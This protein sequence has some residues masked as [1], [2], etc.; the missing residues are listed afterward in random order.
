MFADLERIHAR[1]RPFEFYTASELWTDE[2]TSAQMLA[3]H[4]DENVDLSSRK[5]AFIDRSAD[6]LIGHLGITSGV[7]VVDF[8]CGPGLYT[9]RLAKT[10]A[11]VTGID[12]SARSIAYARDQARTMGLEIN[13]VNQDYLD[14]V[15]QDRFDVVLMIFCDL[16]A[17]SP[18]QRAIML[19]KSPSR[20]ASWGTLHPKPE[21][22][23]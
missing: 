23:L 10:G 14:F 9:S 6:W 1:P 15:T 8:G 3:F 21:S 19:G 11:E 16:C 20:P 12:F 22:P 2:Y 5:T 13:Y 17:L 7:S 4:L 18:A